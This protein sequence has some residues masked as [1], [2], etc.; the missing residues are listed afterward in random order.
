MVTIS[1]IVTKIVDSKP[2]LQEALAREI[3]SYGNLAEQLHKEVEEEYGKKAKLSAIMMALRRYS[4]K[5]QSKL[6]KKIGFEYKSEILL[7][8]NIID[9]S[10]QKSNSLLEKLEKLYKVID[11]GRGDILNII[12]GNFEV[13]IVTNEKHKKDLIKALE[14]EKILN[15]EENLVSLSL[16]FSK[17]FLYTPGILYT[18]ARRFFWENIN[19]F[20]LVSTLTELTYIISKKDATKAYNALQDLLSK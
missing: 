3:I 19:I 9:V 20:E 4:E 8:S 1:H 16:S 11:Y 15:I 10:V 12:H 5:V 7:K 14:G 6:N 2:F 18:C 17:D 13:N